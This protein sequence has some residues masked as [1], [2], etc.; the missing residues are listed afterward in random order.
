MLIPIHP[1]NPQLRNITTVV[2]TLTKG[3]TIIYPTDTIYGLGC[4]IFNHD[5]VEKI[6]AISVSVGFSE[7]FT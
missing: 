6:S 4:D 5:A 3:G 2:E 1:V 7:I